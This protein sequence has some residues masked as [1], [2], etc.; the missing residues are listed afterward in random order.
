MYGTDR[1]AV[2]YSVADDMYCM[3]KHGKPESVKT[4][5]AKM[6]QSFP[7]EYHI[8]EF[9]KDF[10]VSEINKIL[11]ISGYIRM[12]VEDKHNC[13]ESHTLKRVHSPANGTDWDNEYSRQGY[14][15]HRCQACG[16]IWGC[17]YQWD[18]GTGSDDDWKC[19]DRIDPKDVVR[20]Y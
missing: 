5:L 11:H 14:Q 17:R 13:L 20:H 12:L 2:A 15:V 9:D 16:K 18:S 1:V 3:H 6:E 4:W 19:F 10:P 7:G 8:L